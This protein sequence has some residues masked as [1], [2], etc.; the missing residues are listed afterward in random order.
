MKAS[1]HLI[2]IFLIKKPYSLNAFEIDKKSE[3]PYSLL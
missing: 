3:T 2:E 1:F